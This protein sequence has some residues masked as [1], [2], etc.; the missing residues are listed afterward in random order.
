MVGR[1]AK[2][3]VVMQLEALECGAACLTMILAYYDCIVPLEKIRKDCGVSRDGSNA[4]NVL[5]AARRYGLE[6]KGYR[7]D[8]IKVLRDKATFPCIVHWEFNHFIVLCG[9]KGRYAIIN[10]PAKGYMKMPIEEFDEGFTGICLQFAPTEDFVPSGQKKSVFAF[11]GRS[12]RGAASSVAFAAV[13]YAI[14]SVFGLISPILQESFTDRILPGTSHNTGLFFAIAGGLVFLQLVF[15]ILQNIFALRMNGKLS[16]Q[17]NINFLWKLL[18]L[19]MEFFSQRMIGDLEM[20][21]ESNEVVGNVIVQTLSPIFVDGCMLIFYLVVMGRYSPILA[22]ICIFSMILKLW[23]TKVITNMQMNIARVEMCNRGKLASSTVSGIEMIETIKACGAENGFF[24]KWAGY[25]AG[26][27]TQEA[28]HTKLQT[29]IGALPPFITSVTEA[30]VIVFGILMCMRGEMTLGVLIAFQG[31]LTAFSAPVA[32]FLTFGQTFALMR[33]Q[34]ERI[35]DVLEYPEDVRYE[36][37]KSANETEVLQ[38]LTGKI[39]M[40]HVTFGYS[41]LA[42]PLIRDFD[43]E[44]APGRSVAFVGKTGCG[45]ST[46][47]SLISGLYR[48][49]SGEILFDDKK[50]EDIDCDAFT[51]SLAVVTQDITL[52]E[53]TIANNIKMWDSTI[54]DFEMIMAARDA[55]IHEEIMD[56]EGGYQYRLSEGG[57]DFSGGQR[58]RLEIARVLAQDPTI[59]ILDEATSALDAGTEQAVIR[60]IKARGLTCI[61]IAHRLSTIRDCDE[62]IVLDNGLVTERGTHEELLA[63]NGAYAELVKNG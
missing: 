37:G 19:P 49:W 38:K 35:D 13:A 23:L 42:E 20:R 34:M 24:T 54:E 55:M 40:R 58:Q 9:F 14:L 43:L 18:H 59:L 3:P 63:Q 51:G 15:I 2:T 22:A 56:R 21:Q 36:A 52:F 7:Y 46:L 4:R 39:S 32:S 41:P 11:V 16:I 25:Q 60:A 48:P 10:D 33:T 57:R 1:V 12:L 30:A 53:D 8:G 62:I 47:A 26:V 29:Y 31:L 45:K 6:A 61:V 17:G 28:K 5:V 50:I 44:L 27:N